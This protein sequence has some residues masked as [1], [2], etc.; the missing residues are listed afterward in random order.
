M[1]REREYK[2]RVLVYPNI[3]KK[4]N[5][6]MKDSYIVLLPKVIKEISR[7]NKS[8]HFT[9]LNP[10]HLK[11]FDEMKN[12]KQLIYNQKFSSNN[13]TMRTSFFFDASIF[14]EVLDYEENDFDVV[15]SHLPEHTLQVSNLMFNQTYSV[16]KIIG[17]S[18]WFDYNNASV[19]NMSLQNFIGLLEMECCG[20]NSEFLKQQVL[21]QSKKYF[22]DD[23][24][25]KL[26][27]IIQPHELGVDYIDFKKSSRSKIK[28]IAFNHRGQGY[29]GFPFFK[30]AMEKLWKKRKDFRVITFQ[31]D[32]NLSQ[33]KW[34][35]N[36]PPLQIT[37]R[38]EYLRTL[39]DCYIGVGT[40]DGRKGSGGASWSISVFDGLSHGVPYILPNKYVWKDVLPNYPLLYDW[41]N[42]DAFVEMV[43]NVLDD[44]KLYNSASKK[45]QSVVKDMVW[46]K[47]VKKWLDW[48]EFFNPETFQMVGKDI[49][50]Y[51]KVLTII[52][53]H[54]RVS[55]KQLIG[56]LNWGK[57][58]KFGRYRNRLRLDDRIKF[59]KNGYE[60]K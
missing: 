2:F 3:T 39:Q 36:K 48:K 5:E 50:T 1:A 26:D 14:Q 9:I 28:T 27:K 41:N 53:K 55:K 51:K 32:A 6:I 54:K 25:A 18:H 35:D 29:M 59:T 30:S 31:K 44:K 19:K 4:Y 10:I 57:Q 47:Q 60:W 56:E 45:M 12:V 49:A 21:K 7:I 13:N 15:Y 52:K 43:E 20:V 23:V 37:D 38:N 22:N 46:N 33:Y 16:P 42:E 24:V 34:A 8:V 40:F 58:F 17:Y 11:E